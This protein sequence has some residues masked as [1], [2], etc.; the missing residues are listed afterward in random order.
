M[1]FNSLV[2]E[3]SGC[4]FKDQNFSLVLLTDIFRSSY[5]LM[6]LDERHRILLMI[7]QH[8][9]REW[10]GAIKQEAITDANVDLDLCRNMVSLGHRELTMR[11]ILCQTITT[12]KSLI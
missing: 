12:V 10:L 9:L 1:A 5:V 8:W 7:S 6:L 3:K 4:Y 2:P 11:K